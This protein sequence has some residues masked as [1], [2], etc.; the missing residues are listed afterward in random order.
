MTPTE[1]IL[2]VGGLAI[3]LGIILGLLAGMFIW[4]NN[5][6]KGSYSPAYMYL[7]KHKTSPAFRKVID[8]Y[9]NYLQNYQQ[10]FVCKVV[11]PAIDCLYFDPRVTAINALLAEGC[12]KTNQYKLEPMVKR[13]IEASYEADGGDQVLLDY[14]VSYG[15]S[16]DVEKT[17]EI[18][19][20]G[21]TKIIVS[22]F[23]YICRS[24]TET[25]TLQD[26]LVD[27]KMM[28]CPD[29]DKQPVYNA[30][31]CTEMDAPLT[32]S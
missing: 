27:I 24:S 26:I 11:V 6:S 29:A 32:S 25:T 4:N 1:T 10:H 3:F 28:I 8:N 14:Q 15:I 7:Y 9:Q 17:R 20:D 19:V 21:M 31:V 5:D 13:A 12:S 16:M 2:L 18:F 30:S 23:D 22:V